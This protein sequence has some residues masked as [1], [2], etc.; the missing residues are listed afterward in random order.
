MGQVSAPPLRCE[1]RV[2]SAA[3]AAAKVALGLGVHSEK[4]PAHLEAHTAQGEREKML[5][6]NL[7]P[8]GSV[9][10][11]SSAS[12]RVAMVGVEYLTG[13]EELLSPMVAVSCTVPTPGGVHTIMLCMGE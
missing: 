13:S 3:A 6:E 8:A 4:Y 1:G 2:K 11:C 5:M 9:R 7:T 10:D 12:S